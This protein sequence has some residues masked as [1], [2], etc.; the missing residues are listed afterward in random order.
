P[1]VGTATGVGGLFS[2]E[3]T[4]NNQGD[5]QQNVVLAWLPQAV[6][7]NLSSFRITLPAASS[8]NI[9]DIAARLGISGIGSLAVFAIDAR[10]DNVDAS[11]S[12]DGFARILGYPADGG[13]PSSQMIPAVH[14]TL[15]SNTT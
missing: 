11:A 5:R 3:V 7:G 9:V 10:D 8:V 4:L 15:F 1:V 13:A 12:I 2:T 14:S 6:G